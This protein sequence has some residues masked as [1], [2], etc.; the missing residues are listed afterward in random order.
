MARPL[1]SEEEKRSTRLPKPRVTVAERVAIENYA[2]EAGLTVSEFMRRRAL[3][4]PVVTNQVAKVDAQLLSELNRIGV[5]LRS[6]VGNNLNQLVRDWNSG[7]N[8]RLDWA[9]THEHLTSALL[10]LQDLIGKIAEA[11]E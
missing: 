2:A 8:S 9:E 1:K 5:A 11:Y 6:G 3:S 4:R 10:D 7:R